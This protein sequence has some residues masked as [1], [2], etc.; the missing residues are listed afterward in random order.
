MNDI[1]K[2]SS[3]G[4]YHIIL[5]FIEELHVFSRNSEREAMVRILEEAVN[6]KEIEI[7][8]HAIMLNHVHMLI[9]VPSIEV[10]ASVMISINTRF[11]KF[12]NKSRQRRGRVFSKRYFSSAINDENYFFTVFQ[13]I[14]RNSVR[15]Y[16]VKS[17]WDYKWTALKS[18][19]KKEGT[20]YHEEVLERFSNF[21]KGAIFSFEE[22]ISDN[23]N[24]HS[25]MNFDRKLYYDSAAAKIFN[26]ELRMA[27]I[28]ELDLINRRIASGVVLDRLRR[29][30][31][32]YKQINKFSGLTI[33]K[34]KSLEM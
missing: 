15:A 11:A 29:I 21:F 33:S 6:K 32:T 24:D 12:F 13:Y 23:S 7:F 16:L 34:I 20:F 2:E 27:G 8:N 1:R 28:A 19:M 25:I 22:F 10:L 14:S 5:N 31:I 18:Y 9:R 30:G 26:E 17:P 4:E 3:C